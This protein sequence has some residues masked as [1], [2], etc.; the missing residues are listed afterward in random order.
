[1]R[2]PRKLFPCRST[3]FLSPWRLAIFILKNPLVAAAIMDK[4]LVSL[5]IVTKTLSLLA[6]TNHIIASSYVCSLDSNSVS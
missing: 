4:C 3:K 2:V 6:S 1:M 5:E